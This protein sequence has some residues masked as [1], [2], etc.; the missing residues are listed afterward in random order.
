MKSP[1]Y[2]DHVATVGLLLLASIS[3]TLSGCGGGSGGP[4]P[5][6][7]TAHVVNLSWAANKETAV[8]SSGGGYQVA[9]SGQPAIDVPFPYAASGPAAVATLM[10]GSYNVTVSAYSAMNPI[11]GIPASGVTSASLPSSSFAIAVPY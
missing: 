7:P 9:I 10:S 11:T 4:P 8:N 5:P 2:V 6:T 3:L 1:H